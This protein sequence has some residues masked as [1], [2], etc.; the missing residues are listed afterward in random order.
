MS[1]D[2]P[3]TARDRRRLSGIPDDGLYVISVAARL[4][5]MHPQTLRKY[6]RAGLVRP[7]R[8]VGMLRLYSEE[9]IIRL[10]LIKHLVG[11]LGL[12]IAGV[13]LALGM[14]NQMLKMKSELN[15]SEKNDLKEHIETC[16]DEMFSVLRVR[17]S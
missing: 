15:R 2:R 7:S 13:E 4:L 5:E 10:R 11:D 6:E 17:S 12:N 1:V 3:S 9:D 16:L 8:T 14:F